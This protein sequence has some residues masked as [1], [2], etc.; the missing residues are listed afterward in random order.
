MRTVLLAVVLALSTTA[1][2]GFADLKV[3]AGT[4]AGPIHAGAPSSYR[5]LVQNLRG[6]NAA[7]VV[8]NV[9]STVPFSCQCSLGTVFTAG[10]TGVVMTFTAPSTPGTIT[11]NATVTSDTADPD[12]SNN[13]A[14]VTL[15]VSADPDV[16]IHIIAP[17]LQDVSVPFPVKFSFGNNGTTDAHEV[18]ITL[19]FRA[20]VGVQSLPPNCSSPSAGRIVCQIG[21]LGVN[22]SG[23]FAMTLIAPPDYGSGSVIFTATATERGPDFDPANNVS[24]ATTKLFD[25]FYVTTSADAG[26][27]S[28]RQAVID[29]NATCVGPMFCTIVFHIDEPTEAPW[30]RIKLTSPLP[31]LTASGLRIDGATQTKFS[32]DTNPNGPEIEISGGGTV[33]G[34]GLLVAT[35]GAEVA[36]LAIGGFLANGLSVTA[37]SSV[38][39]GY[40]TFELHDLFIGTDPTGSAARPNARGI[41]MSVPNGNDFNSAGAPTNIYNCVISGNTFSGIFG[42]SGRLNVSNNRIG[43]KAHADEP[44]P[45]GNSGVFIGT[46]G[47]GSVV[48]GDPFPASHDF[49]SGA[50]V[51]A[52]NGQTGVAIAAGVKD[53]AVRNNRIWSNRLLGIDVGLDGPT[54]SAPGTFGDPVNAPVLTNAHFDPVSNKTIIEGVVPDTVHI[55]I[56]GL[57]IN[58]YASDAADPSGYGEGQRSIGAVAVAGPDTHFQLAVDGD[59]TGQWITATN[60]RTHYVGFAKPQPE[61]INQGFLTQTSE[62]SRG[63]PVQ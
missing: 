35:C 63:I 13:S 38:C 21:T 52:F 14:T 3:D 31:P 51:I 9:S 54:T 36:N 57:V 40:Y 2:F 4:P 28:L 23:A 41:G 8:V 43:V 12:P 59:L 7:N 45:N 55:D 17:A 20:D 16:Y 26:P 60:T 61:G 50:N 34:H 42:M 47:Y 15:T 24:V 58:I 22:G 30:K 56:T 25:T 32:G 33:N 39:T 48:G 44:L 18:V 27:G 29:A 11:I 49:V 62:F 6:E 10:T 46:G 1:L 53:V 19:D 37:P 5:F